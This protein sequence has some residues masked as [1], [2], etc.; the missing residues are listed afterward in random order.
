MNPAVFALG[1][2]AADG[3]LIVNLAAIGTEVI[4]VSIGIFGNAHVC[5]TD[6]AVRVLLMM[7]RYW[8]F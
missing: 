5:G 3:F 2:L 1:N 6:V 8:Q 7:H 4:P